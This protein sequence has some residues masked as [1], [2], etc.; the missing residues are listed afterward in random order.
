MG[1][2]HIPFL[3]AAFCILS[4]SVS[5]ATFDVTNGAEFES[6][7]IAA[8]SNGEADTINL[9]AGLYTSSNPFEYTAAATENFPLTISGAGPTLTVLDGQDARRVLLIDTTTVTPDDTAAAVSIS[10]V[11]IQNGEV[12]EANSAGG[13]LLVRAIEANLSLTNCLVQRNRIIPASSNTGGAFLFGFNGEVSVSNCIFAGNL[14]DSTGGLRIR[15]EGGSATVTNNLFTGNKSLDILGIGGGMRMDIRDGETLV[16]GNRF[17]RNESVGNGGGLSILQNGAGETT[18]VNNV[19]FDN[20]SGASGD[21]GGG[22]GLAFVT[23]G[24]G[25]FFLVNNTIFANRTQDS[26]NGPGGGGGVYLQI[27]NDV[28]AQLYNNIVFGNEADGDGDDIFANDD[29][30]E[31]DNG[32]PLTLVSNDFSD[33]ATF[34]QSAGG[35][36]TDITQSANLPGMNPL[37]LNSSQ[38]DLRISELSPCIDE[39]DPA[40]PGLPA[41][42]FEG[43]P[44]VNGSAPDIG[45]DEQNFCGDGVQGAAEACDDGN[46]ADGDGCSASC[47][48]ETPGSA[49][50]SPSPDGDDDDD[51]D[52]G[53]IG[54]GGCSLN[55]EGSR[56][57]AGSLALFSILGI[58]ALG[59]RRRY[60]R[61]RGG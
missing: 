59:L 4:T 31:D 51:D 44:R 29:A 50:P 46:T 7:L 57:T 12:V 33:F 40:A 21:P 45:A 23:N 39:G 30:D 27:R 19:F 8:Q 6:A 52:D 16:Q 38:G 10:G 55:P 41:I 49:T 32:A 48:E 37:F 24:S 34:C 17:D 26:G 13:G 1:N 36:I 54:G 43:D 25:T 15:A 60:L 22:G 5:A 35:C 20:L 3:T 9:A 53:T 11:T 42:D 28:E 61:V 18:V 56:T 58:S 47:Q 2:R 14:S